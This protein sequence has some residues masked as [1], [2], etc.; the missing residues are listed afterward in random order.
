MA[1]SSTADHGTGPDR[2]YGVF[3]TFLIYENRPI[4]LDA[5]LKRLRTSVSEVYGEELPPARDLVLSRAQGGG[6]GRLRLD[7][8]PRSGGG[9]ALSVIVAGVDPSNVFPSGEFESALTT[10]PVSVAQGAHKWAARDPLARAEARCGPGLVPLLVIEDDTVL[11]ASRANVFA[12]FE[13]R[14]VTPPLDGRILPGVARGRVLE[15]A[16]GL[17]LETEQRQLELGELTKAEEVFLTG[18]VRGIEPVR[19]IDDQPL[20][21]SRE[22]T[23][24]LATELRALW[25]ET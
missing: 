6:L 10:M 7:A 2:R 11:E 12:V 25:L 23:A 15:I 5:H 19:A 3:E 22:L 1:H 13:G 24:K 14:V 17:G 16:A 20:G 21:A 4:E 9:I 8:R 18:S